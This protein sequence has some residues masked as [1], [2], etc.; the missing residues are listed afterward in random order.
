MSS[1]MNAD[2]VKPI[3]AI[4][5][6]VALDKY[7]LNQQDLNSSLYFGVATGAGI[8]AAGLFKAYLPDLSTTFATT[9]YYSAKTVETRLLEV[10]LATGAGYAVNTYVLKNTSYN[11][12]DMMKRLAVVVATDFI[13]EYMS[14]YATAAPLS[15]FI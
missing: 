3:A 10:A 5:V 9:S 15:Y 2:Y 13:S 8:A 4:G 11:N 14:D 7:V 6:A 12:E 1:M